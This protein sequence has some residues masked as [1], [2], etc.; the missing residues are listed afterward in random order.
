MTYHIANETVRTMGEGIKQKR[1]GRK[2]G[3][4]DVFMPHPIKPYHGLFIEFKR[5]CGEVPSGKQLDMMNL[6]S[7][8]GFKVETAFGWEHAKQ[9]TEKYLKCTT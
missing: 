4:P 2:A 5:R 1:M 7:A 9:I 8:E 3:V 6:L